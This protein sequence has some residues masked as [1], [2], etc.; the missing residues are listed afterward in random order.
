MSFKSIIL[1]AAMLTLAGLVVA[2][3]GASLIPTAEEQSDDHQASP[4]SPLST[5]SPL[6]PLSTASPLP[7]VTETPALASIPVSTAEPL[8]LI[9][10][11]TNDNWGET[12]PCG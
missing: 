9:V 3:C 11:H 8:E 6:S 12:E 5:A 2:G 10:L 1:R 7:M 4:L